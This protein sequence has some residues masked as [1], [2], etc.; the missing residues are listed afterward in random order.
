MEPNAGV[1]QLKILI[2]PLLIELLQ[3]I[4][5]DS[6]ILQDGPKINFKGLFFRLS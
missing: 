4:K 6:P 5:I 3:Q 2:H 1:D